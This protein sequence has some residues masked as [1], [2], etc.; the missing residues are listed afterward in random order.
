[1]SELTL[2]NLPRRECAESYTTKSAKHTRDG[3]Q[4]NVRYVS[5]LTTRKLSRAQLRAQFATTT[6][7]QLVKHP[8]TPCKL[9]TPDAIRTRDPRIRNPVLY[10]TELRGLA[11]R[12]LPRRGSRVKECRAGWD[13]PVP[14]GPPDPD[15]ACCLDVEEVDW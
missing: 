6:R 8:V 14:L 2:L 3:S 11:D 9:S 12:V 1:M 13:V 15:G 4:D 10:P 7:P 5:L